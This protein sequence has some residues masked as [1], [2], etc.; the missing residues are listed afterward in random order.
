M[1]LSFGATDL[2]EDMFVVDQVALGRS[3]HLR[4]ALAILQIPVNR[5]LLL[6]YSLGTR[7]AIL[8]GQVGRPRYRLLGFLYFERHSLYGGDSPKGFLVQI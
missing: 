1:A 2:V 5:N 8:L 6:E 4:L 3:A 7:R